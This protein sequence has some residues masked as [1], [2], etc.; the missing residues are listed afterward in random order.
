MMSHAEEVAMRASL[1]S[2]LTGVVDY[3]GLFPPAKL[4]LDEALHCYLRYRGE[5]ER[6]M[7]GRFVIPAAR[8]GELASFASE[9]PPDDPVRFTVLCRSGS[10]SE[11][12]LAGL[13]ADL[14]EV[15]AFERQHASR[16]IVESC[17]P[18]FHAALLHQISE[19]IHYL[20]ESARMTDGRFARYFEATGL[21]DWRDNLPR[22]LAALRATLG[23]GGFK[24]R[25]GGL[26]PQAFPSSDRLAYV[27]STCAREG[28]P[29][30]FT[31]GLH[32]P[33]RRHDP[34]IGCTMHGFVNVLVAAAL[35][36]TYQSPE[37]MLQAVLDDQN[38]SRFHFTDEFLS[39]NDQRLSLAQ[40]EQARSMLPG[41][42]SCSFDEPRDDLR[43]LGW[44]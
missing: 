43:R 37:P 41:F 12:L 36:Y 1:R 26:E 25:T 15:R 20:D 7:L 10:S 3:A 11:A 14:T 30:K 29:I 8:L 5:P 9:F 16:V 21:I 4:P 23:K 13:Q 17:E 18:T 42:G 27:L 32:H 28:V 35:A 2:L 39:W 44:I 31:A 38:P 24:L 40:I 34:G 19:L 33:I 6:W 22:V